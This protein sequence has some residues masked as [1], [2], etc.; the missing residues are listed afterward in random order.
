M[1]FSKN[2]RTIN[3]TLLAQ[4]PKPEDLSKEF[5]RTPSAHFQESIAQCQPKGI[6]PEVAASTPGK[7]TEPSR[8]EGTTPEFVP[9]ALS[10]LSPAEPAEERRRA[11]AFN[12]FL[13]AFP[14]PPPQPAAPSPAPAW[15][16][17]RPKLPTETPGQ[18]GTATPAT[19]PPDQGE[20]D[21]SGGAPAPGTEQASPA[22][23]EGKASAAGS[24]PPFHRAS[25]V[26]I[27]ERSPPPPPPPTALVGR[28]VTVHGS[29]LP[30][31]EGESGYV[32]EY[33]PFG[34]RYHVQ[35][36]NGH[37]YHLVS[38]R[39]HLTQAPA[40]AAQLPPMQQHPLPAT[41]T[42]KYKPPPVCFARPT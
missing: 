35:L 22:T 19:S 30:S 1:D 7:A 10:Q 31:I 34:E 33:D 6:P 20:A 13:D 17:W 4:T 12:A 21:V 29:D 5:S 27:L 42:H 15:S 18:Q 14:T 25:A 41:M 3:K 38:R 40:K 26:T 11:E 36:N 24:Y 8:T 23:V 39:L 9:M 2:P 16:T 32:L 28:H 37:V